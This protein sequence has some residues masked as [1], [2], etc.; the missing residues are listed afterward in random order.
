VKFPSQ[1]HLVTELATNWNLWAISTSQIFSEGIY[2]PSKIATEIIVTIDIYTFVTN[3]WHTSLTNFV[4]HISVAFLATKYVEYEIF[5]HKINTHHFC[6][7]LFSLTKL[8]LIKFVIES[9]S[10]KTNTHH[11]CYGIF[12]FTKLTL[13]TFAMKYFPSQT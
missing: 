1:T 10:H 3:D 12:S 4:I 2:H 13:I 11:F 5:H 7:E 6:Y 9:F 8:T